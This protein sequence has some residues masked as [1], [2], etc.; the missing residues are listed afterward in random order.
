MYTIWRYCTCNWFQCWTE[1]DHCCSDP[2][3]HRDPTWL[4]VN[5]WTDWK[6]DRDADMCHGTLS[7]FKCRCL[8]VSEKIGSCDWCERCEENGRET[9]DCD[10][11]CDPANTE[12]NLGHSCVCED[13][14]YGDCCFEGKCRRASFC[15]CTYKHQWRE[16]GF[17]KSSRVYHIFVAVK[18]KD[19]LQLQLDIHYS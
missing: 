2:N 10:L 11:A 7:R 17:W 9:K 5:S 16:N 15:V 13:E 14:H 12:T 8:L 1:G 18:T 3:W 4:S 6:C 19:V